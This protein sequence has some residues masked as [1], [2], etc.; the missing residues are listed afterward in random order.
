MSLQDLKKNSRSNLEALQK[1]I[2]KYNKPYAQ[3]GDD[4][5]WTVTR[6]KA[7]NGF[8]VIRFLDSPEGESCPWVKVFEHGFQGS[9]GWY[10]EKSLTTIGKKDPVAELNSRLW[11]S[12]LDDN[13]AIAR[14][15]KRQLRYISN[16]L[17]IKDP[18]HPE[19]E[20][21]VFLF[22]Y[23]KKIFDKINEM[24]YPE[25]IEGDDEVVPLNPFDFWKGANF[26]LKVKNAD[27]YINYDSSKFDQQSALFDDDDQ[28]E[29]VY[30]K[31]YSLSEFVDPKN[32]KT[33]EELKQRLDSILGLTETTEVRE[34]KVKV[35]EKPVVSK[36]EESK[37][38]YD[39]QLD[40]EEF[41]AL[42]SL[43]D[44]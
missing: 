18:A 28:I 24:L 16:I 9:N 10:I 7:G 22:K 29:K 4:R 44:E 3:G 14:K 43:I 5:F 36:K 2:E 33:Y 32:F 23:G 12:G 20:G 37:V 11:N 1:E 42:A 6:D 8:A 31:E 39:D 30:K 17:V 21:K 26:R 38:E 27:G 41:E 40:N 19:N 13:K 25:Q 34:Q 35:T 15:Q